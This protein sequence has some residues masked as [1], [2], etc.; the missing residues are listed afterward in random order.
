MKH[1]YKNYNYYTSNRVE[2]IVTQNVTCPISGLHQKS[3]HSDLAEQ[4]KD[5]HEQVRLAVDYYK[6]RGY[7]DEKIRRVVSFFS[8]H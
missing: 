5:T 8:K 1:N 2:Q 6:R 3:H 7:R 4:L